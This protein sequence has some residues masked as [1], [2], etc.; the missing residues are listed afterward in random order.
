MWTARGRDRCCRR[1]AIVAAT[2]TLA[3]SIEGKASEAPGLSAIELLRLF[4][5][6]FLAFTAL[7]TL[8][9]PLERWF[10]PRASPGNR[11]SG[12][13]PVLFV[14]GIYCNAA[15][16]WWIRRYLQARGLHGTFT[17][18]LE[19]P[20]GDIDDYAG[21]LAR[22]IDEVC[23]TTGSSHVLV[24][25]HSMGGLVARACL[26]NIAGPGRIAKLIT[27]GSPHHGSGLAYWGVGSHDRQLLPGSPWLQALNRD[28]SKAPRAPIISIFTRHDNFVA[29]QDS[30]VLAHATN[31]PLA[32]IGISPCCFPAWW[33]SAYTQRSSLQIRCET[34]A[35]TVRTRSAPGTAAAAPPDL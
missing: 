32:G 27:L 3:T 19:P 11:P 14:H 7:F 16:W 9:Q 26:Q 4:W 33:Q 35:R 18:D 31:V 30:S 28:E 21:Q 24:I 23:E 8:L 6:E 25:G 1:L 5:F 13:M 20:V 22:R 12:R 29:P 2:F 34:R 15:V 17:I 10:T